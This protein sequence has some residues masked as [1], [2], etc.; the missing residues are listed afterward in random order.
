MRHFIII[1]DNFSAKIQIQFRGRA[2]GATGD[3][4][5]GRWGER[6]IY[7]HGTNQRSTSELRQYQK[8][9]KCD[10]VRYNPEYS[11]I[12]GCTQKNCQYSTRGWI[13]YQRDTDEIHSLK[14]LLK[15]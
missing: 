5:M 6:R 2:K 11:R 12:Q 1:D 14:R 10:K 8:T 7:D 4:A 13:V 15:D 9:D 3:E